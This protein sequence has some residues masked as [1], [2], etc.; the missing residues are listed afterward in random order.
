MAAA[1]AQGQIEAARV[2]AAYLSAFLATETGKRQRPPA[3]DPRQ[4]AGF[5]RDGRP[6]TDSLRS[7]LIGTL[8]ALK[9]GRSPAESLRIGLNRATRMV[10]VDYDHA[11]RTALLSAI[12]SDERFDGWRRVTGGTCAACAAKAGTLETGLRFQVHAGCLCVSEPSVVGVADRIAR[13][14]GAQIFAAKSR[15]EQDEMLGPENAERVRRGEIT[16]E[17]LSGESEMAR[18]QNFIT[19]TSAT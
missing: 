14:T 8:A 6:L 5:S 19:Q 1:V 3:L 17:D 2:T 9:K 16:L 18:G 15:A 11:H 4:F 10:G 12:D 7:P 13:H